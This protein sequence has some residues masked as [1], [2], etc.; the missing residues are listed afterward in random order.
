[1]IRRVLVG[2]DFSETSEG[3]LRWGVDLAR[4]HDGEVRLLHALR[5]PSL[6]TPYVPV[7]PEI[8]SASAPCVVGPALTD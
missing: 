4:A 6:A 7:P 8:R 1:M 2:T 5:L 3:A